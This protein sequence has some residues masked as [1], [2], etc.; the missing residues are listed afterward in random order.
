MKIFYIKQHADSI[1]IKEVSKFLR[2]RIIT[3]K[4]H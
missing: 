1:E 4:T 2:Q 3:T